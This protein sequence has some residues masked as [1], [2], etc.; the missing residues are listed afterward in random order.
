MFQLLRRLS[1][2]LYSTWCYNIFSDFRLFRRLSGSLE[3]TRRCG[4]T[5]LFDVYVRAGGG[6]WLTLSCFSLLKSRLQAVPDSKIPPER[7]T[8][9]EGRPTNSCNLPESV[10]APR[11][12]N[13]RTQPSFSWVREDCVIEV[14]RRL[15]TS[16]W[17]SPRR[18]L[19]RDSSDELE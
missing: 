4:R 12:G 7:R 8:P 9:P 3:S 11:N 14:D 15:A 17:P 10:G 16:P 2:S 18:R 1:E 5:A 19:S 6:C 13:N